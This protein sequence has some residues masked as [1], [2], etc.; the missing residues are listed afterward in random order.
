MKLKDKIRIV[1]SGSLCI[2]LIFGCSTKKNTPVT[3]AYHELTTRY[4]VF[5]NA[6]Q[7]YNETLAN[8]LENLS[9]DYYKLLPFYPLETIPG[10]TTPGG[11]FD[12]VIDKT[13]KA[14]REHSISTKPRRIS[15]KRYSQEQLQ[16]FRQEEYNP[17]M[18][19]AWL[20]M[21][22]AFVQ[23]RDYEEALSV[24]GQIL[25]LYKDDA[26]VKFE[27]E[28]WMLRI[29][30]EMN[31][32]YD[33]DN[34]A[35]VLKLKTVPTHLN[36]I[37][38]ETYTLYLLHKKEYANAIPYLKRAIGTEKNHKQQKRLQ[39]LLGQVYAILGE[40]KNAYQAFEKVKGLTTPYN[41]LL[42]ATVYQTALSTG[43]QQ[44]KSLSKWINLAKRE[45]NKDTTATAYKLY[46][47][48]S[49][50]GSDYL[51]KT[52]Y[53]GLTEEKPN[54]K[55]TTLSSLPAPQ[56]RIFLFTY[57]EEELYQKAY[58]AYKKGVTASVHNAFE[59]F[60]V[61]HPGS[62][63]MPQFL[64][65]N[66]LSY[67]QTGNVAQTNEYLNKL[68]ESFPDSDAA[69]IAENIVEAI[70]QGRTLADNASMYVEWNNDSASSLNQKKVKY[71]NT[72]FSNDKK[73]PHLFLLLFTQNYTGKNR[74]LFATADFNFSHFRY[75]R[76]NLS[77]IPLIKMEALSVQPF[78][79]FEEASQYAQTILSDSIFISA[80]TKEVF[81]VVIS[82]ENI[83]LLQIPEDIEEYLTFCRE[84]LNTSPARVQQT[85][86]IVK[87]ETGKNLAQKEEKIVPLDR[88]SIHV[89][90]G[91]VKPIR[92][93]DRI[94]PDE[95]KL[96]LEEKAAESIRQNGKALEST[97][98]KALQKK[99]ERERKEKIRQR[100]QELKRRQRLRE[101]ELKQ[102]ER[103]RDLK[104]R[105]QEGTRR[106]KLNEREA[107]LRNQKK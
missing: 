4:N 79:S 78:N 32:T 30:T 46:R 57:P 91:A 56:S 101:I 105:E 89:G 47:I 2:A 87:A 50:L 84:Y 15:S 54:R 31:R 42:N 28:I 100:E 60:I 20:L 13:T 5:F 45:V 22:K 44:H 52:L 29:Y 92:Q 36:T 64:L 11:P 16:W 41:L 86:M 14:I 66:A 76:F 65:L 6:Q 71:E 19:N 70:S 9:D 75:R 38:T 106:E 82:E 58:E 98:R 24:F 85:E 72:L 63:L 74:L 61:K 103:E 99:R 53:Q 94:T 68:L 104:I 107:L 95:L 26:D 80:L 40:N 90:E 69:P 37:F 17:F 35:Y 27:T 88:R 10:K 96:R 67:A 43:E 21:G 8:Q 62:G 18:K 7:A 83:S 51:S 3:R 25:R 93:T 33:A 12:G 77:F 34:M 102:R 73:G 59:E 23:N 1:I 97:N 48:Y 39:F 55:E 49:E 81:P